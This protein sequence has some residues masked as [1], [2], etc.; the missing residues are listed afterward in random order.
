M[1][2]CCVAQVYE[3]GL[4]GRLDAVLACWQELAEVR[5]KLARWVSVLFAW[6][7]T[8]VCVALHVA[9]DCIL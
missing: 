6:C 9:M 2:P 5:R 8:L 3:V 1:S 4:L 7:Y